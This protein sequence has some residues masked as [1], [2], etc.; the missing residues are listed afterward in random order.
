M[1]AVCCSFAIFVYRQKRRVGQLAHLIFPVRFR[2]VGCS[3]VRRSLLLSLTKHNRVEIS[4][5]AV[6][7]VPNDICDSDLLQALKKGSGEAF[8][9]LYNKFW[10]PM[11]LLAY[12]K[13]GEKETAEEIVQEIFTKL[14]R[15]RHNLKIEHFERYLFSSV[16]YE[17]IDQI[18]KNL[19]KQGY[20]K[21][22][23]A[24]GAQENS[25]TEETVLYND[26]N[27]RLDSAIAHLPEKTREVFLH[28]KTH[29]WPLAKI[30]RKM[31]ISEKTVEYHLSKAR[32]QIRDSLREHLIP[33]LIALLNFIR[34][35]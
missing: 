17:V 33:T 27:S 32:Q 24:Y 12:R 13:L 10:Y 11:F 34:I 23:E 21:Y 29:N 1:T 28:A 2:I 20:R 9:T 5:I 26:L 35:I 30:A 6:L 15:D 31:G 25:S 18:R 7:M 22:H 16:R 8:T 14:W 4:T 19:H 3:K